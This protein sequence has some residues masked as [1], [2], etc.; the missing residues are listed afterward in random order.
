MSVAYNS[1]VYPNPQDYPKPHSPPPQREYKAPDTTQN[2]LYE[3]KKREYF[4]YTKF[5]MHNE[6][7][8]YC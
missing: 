2:L 6:Y 8:V 5:G 7:R 4:A 1:L 3:K